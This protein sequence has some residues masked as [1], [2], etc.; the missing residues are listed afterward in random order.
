MKKKLLIIILILL[1]IIV[2][3]KVALRVFTLNV[4]SY[5]WVGEFSYKKVISSIDLAS[6]SVKTE[7]FVN[8]TEVEME[9]DW[10][11]VHDRAELELAEK[12]DTYMTCYDKSEDIWMVQFGRIDK[13]TNYVIW[14]ETVYLNGKGVTVLITFDEQ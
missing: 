14:F 1:G 3:Y 7:G 12:H 9:P 10:P 8:T 11:F 4:K 5:P 13:T 6:P 2:C